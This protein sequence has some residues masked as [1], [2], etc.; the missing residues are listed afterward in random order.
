[1]SSEDAEKSSRT[2][3]FCCSDRSWK[4]E[5]TVAIIWIARIAE[6]IFQRIWRFQQL[7][8]NRALAV[9]KWSSILRILTTD[10]FKP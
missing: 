6:L 8:G 4:P 2:F 1:M 7:Y 5:L 9:K 3:A 10:L